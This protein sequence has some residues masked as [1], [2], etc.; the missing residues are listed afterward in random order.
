M[1]SHLKHNGLPGPGSR[2]VGFIDIAL[3][4]H[5]PEEG[6]PESHIGKSARITSP[7][8][9]LSYSH[10]SVGHSVRRHGASSPLPA[11]GERSDREAI[12][13]RGLFR[14]SLSA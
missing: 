3:S 6:L 10:I 2:S 7:R 11:R 8:A 13:V 5:S 4:L 1:A 14:E 12:R 9:R